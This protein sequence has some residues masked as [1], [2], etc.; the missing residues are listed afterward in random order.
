[1]GLLGL[2]VE[3]EVKV[4]N[5]KLQPVGRFSDSTILSLMSWQ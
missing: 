5:D 4:E 2:K 1:M 3:V